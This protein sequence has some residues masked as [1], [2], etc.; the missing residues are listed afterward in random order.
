MANGVRPATNR[1][2]KKMLLGMWESPAKIV[3]TIEIGGSLKI[4]AAVRG[5]NL[6]GRSCLRRVVGVKMWPKRRWR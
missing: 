5:I 2:M 6:G 4:T 3:V 1:K